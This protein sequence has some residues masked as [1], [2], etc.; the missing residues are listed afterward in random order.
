MTKKRLTVLESKVMHKVLEAAYYDPMFP[1]ALTG[2]EKSALTRLLQ[3]KSRKVVN[4]LELS[5][6]NHW[7]PGQYADRL[8]PV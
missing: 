8:D 3:K 7:P 2:R 4:S 5:E 6:F 1:V